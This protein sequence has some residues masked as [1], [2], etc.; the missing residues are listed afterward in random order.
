MKTFNVGGLNPI[1]RFKTLAEAVS[2]ATDD[3]TI[4]LHKDVAESIAIKKNIIIKGNKHTFTVPTGKV[5]LDGK[6]PFEIYDLKIKAQTRANAIRSYYNIVM[7]NVEVSLIGPIRQ[8]YPVVLIEPLYTDGK[9]V[10]TPKVTINS[11]KFVMLNLGAGVKSE[12][13]D[14]ELSSYYCGNVMLGTREDM[15]QINGDAVLNN[16]KLK[17]TILK[18]NVTLNQCEINK[19]VDI[20]SK[21]RMN[22]CIL[23]IEHEEVKK[24]A[25]KKEPETGPL[26]NNTDSKYAIAIRDKGE[27]TLNNY[28]VQNV[29]DDF[30][31]IY[32]TNATIVVD[33]VNQPEHLIDHIVS[34]SNVSLKNV[35]D[36]NYWD[37]RDSPTA[38]VRSEINS[39]NKH[40]AAKDKLNNLIGQQTVKDQVNS[41]MNTIN[42]NNESNNKDFDF[43]YNMIFAGSPGTG[44]TTIARIVAQALFEIGAIPQNKFTQATSDTFVKGYVGQSGENTRKILDGALGGV[45]FI[46][47]AYQLTVKDN[48]NSF[49]SDV[50]SVLIRYMEDHRSDLVVIAAGYNKEMKEFLASNEGLTRRFQ[51][52]QFEDYTNDELGKIFELM[53]KSYSDT[54][55]DPI[56]AQLIVPLF[57]RVT[58]TNLSI[59][60]AK[61]RVNNGGNGGLVRLI[62]QAISQARNNRVSD[63]GGTRAFTKEDI[64]AGFKIEINKALQRRL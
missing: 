7:S 50:I 2:K 12:I 30:L 38:Y 48:E 20:D 8:F 18:G 43:S 26:S 11:C 6:V 49:N 63:T 54:Y 42:M 41:I 1:R 25:Y 29:E 13:N 62:Y 55:A 60:D 27:L 23:N 56:L 9:Q 53:R 24:N 14:S 39:N 36:K 46:D 37:I 40:V 45:L 31:G 16:C 5:G 10:T 17:S 15:N 33:N 3:D 44:K 21:V 34:N 58:E 22:D 47:E 35:H 59:P 19:Y 61:G 4:E 28:K 52:I 57:Q 32:A 64:A 51:W